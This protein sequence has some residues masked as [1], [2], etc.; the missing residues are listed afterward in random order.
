MQQTPKAERC[1]SFNPFLKLAFHFVHTLRFSCVFS[2][3]CSLARIKLL[4]LLL[5]SSL[6]LDLFL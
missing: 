2:M 5:D 4:K 1:S 3:P 6:K